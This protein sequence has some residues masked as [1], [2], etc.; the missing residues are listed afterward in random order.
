[1]AD[2]SDFKEIL[3]PANSLN[4]WRDES[5]ETYAYCAKIDEFMVCVEISKYDRSYF[6]AYLYESVTSTSNNSAVRIPIML[7]SEQAG[8][9][10]FSNFR[11]AK[12]ELV[13]IKILK[14]AVEIVFQNIKKDAAYFDKLSLINLG[15]TIG[16]MHG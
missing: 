4:I 11:D 10:A 1:M 6:S 7:A 8:E 2:D 5:D 12:N 13:K 9:Y 16:R 14:R 3:A 15:Y